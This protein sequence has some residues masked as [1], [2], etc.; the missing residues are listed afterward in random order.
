MPLP[1]PCL[2]LGGLRLGLGHLCL[3]NL[4][5]GRGLGRERFRLCDV[6][7]PS[8]RPDPLEVQLGDLDLHLGLLCLSGVGLADLGHKLLV[9]EGVL[10][11]LELF[12]GDLELQRGR[13]RQELV[14]DRLRRLV[15]GAR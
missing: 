7:L 4:D 6:F 11:S 15:G 12:L 2:R 9:V 10:G 8:T 13:P 5:A 14:V 3:G 1:D